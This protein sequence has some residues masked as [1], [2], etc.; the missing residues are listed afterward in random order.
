M[1]RIFLK[2]SQIR[3]VDKKI[4]LKKQIANSTGIL[5]FGFLLGIIAKWLDTLPSDVLGGIFES[6]NLG[7]FFSELSIWV[8]L[9]VCISLYS[10]SPLRAGINVF[11][12]FL[13]M[14]IGYFGY[15]ELV[16]HFFPK[17]YMLYWLIITVISPI[18]AYVTW[19]A[20]GEG[21]FSLVISSVIIAELFTQAF[22]WGMFYFDIKSILNVIVWIIGIGVLYKTPKQMCQMIGCSI[23]IAILLKQMNIP[24][25]Y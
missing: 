19:Y 12:F 3:L 6:W 8:L 7:I 20:K 25:F 21:V 17:S 13:G 11:L 24:F 14:L 15:T 10:N 5:F 1:N 2:F 18:F 22:A 4:T 9:A 16:L 23:L